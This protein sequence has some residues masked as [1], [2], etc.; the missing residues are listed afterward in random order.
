MAAPVN[1]LCANV[2]NVWV[3]NRTTE[4]VQNLNI[5]YDIINTNTGWDNHG[6]WGVA[7]RAGTSPTISPGLVP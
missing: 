6:D 5:L 4:C 2:N 1:P 3:V 7:M